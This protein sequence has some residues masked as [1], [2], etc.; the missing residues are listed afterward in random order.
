MVGLNFKKERSTVVIVAEGGV[1]W[2]RSAP[3]LT[4][5]SPD[6]GKSRCGSYPSTRRQPWA[7]TC[8]GDSSQS[9][10]R[11]LSILDIFQVDTCV[12]KRNVE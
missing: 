12:T 10:A 5:T 1:T 6:S 9:Q 11:A 2:K 3:G 7:L 4:G 8:P